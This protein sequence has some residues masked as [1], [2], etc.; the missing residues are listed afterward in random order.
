MRALPPEQRDELRYAGIGPGD[1]YVGIWR[2]VNAYLAKLSDV[3]NG[4][5]HDNITPARSRELEEEWRYLCEQ[6]V[7]I[8][9]KI[10]PFE[11]AKLN[12]V[13]VSGD[14]QQGAP[15]KRSSLA[16]TPPA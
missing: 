6:V 2:M 16:A 3:M 1:S 5:S 12:A 9:A 15:R 13:T 14:Q 7:N 10:L 11:K 4:L 8:Y